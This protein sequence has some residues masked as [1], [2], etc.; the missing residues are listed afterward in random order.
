MGERVAY[1]LARPPGWAHI[2][3][4]EKAAGQIA[5]I[6]RSV[7]RSVDVANRG[8]AEK[9]IA[10]QL[11]TAIAQAGQ[12]GAQDLFFPTEPIDGFAIP[13][14]IVVA[15]PRLPP[16]AEQQPRMQALTAF[17][18]TSANT[19][20][21]AVAGQPAVRGRRDVPAVYDG[22][23]NLTVPATRQVS[24]VLW[25]PGPDSRLITILGSFV[26]L[27]SPDGPELT[28]ALEFLFDTMIDTVR[29][30]DVET[31]VE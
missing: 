10:D 11:N 23:D 20:V 31:L 16:G 18:A 29:F 21:T 15:T 1:R 30:T 27:D 9:F 3:V 26:R 4:G 2:E 28:E 8:V 17:A 13:L 19:T 12:T 25:S 7:A 6:A 24:Y 5:E 14:S 22:D